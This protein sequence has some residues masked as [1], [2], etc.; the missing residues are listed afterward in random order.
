MYLV[1]YQSE[2]K[3]KRCLLVLL[4]FFST[5]NIN[6]QENNYQKVEA[7]EGYENFTVNQITQDRFNKIWLSTS[8]GLLKFDGVSITR[9]KTVET[10]Q[11]VSTVFSKNDSL[12]IGKDKSLQLKTK[13]HLLTFEAKSVNKIFEYYNKYFIASSQGIHFFNK[14][15]LQALKTT[16]KLDFSIVNDIIFHENEFIV[17]SNSGIWRLSNLLHP[18]KTVLISAGSYASLLKIK[19][20]LFVLK[21][22]SEIQELTKENKLITKYDKLEMTNISF[23]NN[24][25]YVTSK[26]EGI[27]VLNSDNFIFEK[28]IN[29]YNSN[30]DSNTINAVFEDVEKN[31]FIATKN[32]LYLKKSKPVTRNL[33]LEIIDLKVNYASV[34]SINLNSYKD[35]LLLNPNQN[36]ISFLLQSVSISAPKN[37]EFRYKLNDIFSP[38]S[39]NNQMNFTHLNP[40]KYEFKV[41]SRFKNTTIS[42]SKIFSF[43]IDSPIY[44]KVWFL[45]LCGVILCLL[46]AGILELNSRKIN[47]R[48]KQEVSALKLENHLLTL[49]QKALQL[50]MNPHFIFNVL[51]GIKALGNSDNKKELNKTISQFSLLLRSVLN[52]SRLEEISLKE[53]IETLENYLI[54]EQKMTSKTFKF[55]FETNLNNMDSEE[56]LVPPMLL[57]P[58]IENAIKHGVSKIASKGKIRVLFEVKDHFLECTVRDNGIGFYQ[59][60]KENSKKN[61]TSVALKVTKERIENLSK[62]SAFSVEEINEENRILGTEIWFKIPLK[63]DY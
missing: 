61:H 44:K 39:A 62:F 28:R 16:Y 12:F 32:G 3:I 40:G 57:Q 46:L 6:S 51:N 5:F 9:F 50:Q 35:I 53:E 60:Q 17:A 36:N 33:T 14:D 13:H 48:N 20:R 29:K 15:Y 55:S 24:K 21:N 2:R 41:E 63:T 49:E 59:S 1:P 34:D 27:D 23:I 58:F 52:N 8:K 11:K 56:I 45:L 26:N 19:N 31:I 42:S 7:F 18:K 10:P 38:W 37:I 22:N 25:I 54:L 47:R 43:F 4:L 30:L